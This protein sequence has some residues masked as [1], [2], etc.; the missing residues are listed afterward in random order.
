MK[1]G[2]VLIA[3]GMVVALAS[4]CAS[5]KPLYK[6]ERRAREEVAVLK[7]ATTGAITNINGLALEG[8]AYELLPGRY[9]VNFRSYFRGELINPAAKGQRYRRD[10]TTEFSAEA[11]HLYEISEGKP[12]YMTGNRKEA[13]REMY[14][15]D[16]PVYLAD[17]DSKGMAIKAT[18]ADCRYRK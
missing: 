8:R 14:V 5:V 11:G 15:F 18:K 7:L 13:G 2:S 4:A 16:A 9:E 10:C 1:L 17:V 3:G 12:R 6:G